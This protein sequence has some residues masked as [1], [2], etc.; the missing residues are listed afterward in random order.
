MRGN[1]VHFKVTAIHHNIVLDTR[2]QLSTLDVRVNPG[3]NYGTE[4]FSH[5]SLDV[6]V[7]SR[8]LEKYRLIEIFT[9][10]TILFR[11][12]IQIGIQRG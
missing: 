5:M 12:I 7:S 1:T 10:V 2:N 8:V 3:P 9:K 11:P 4:L 6:I